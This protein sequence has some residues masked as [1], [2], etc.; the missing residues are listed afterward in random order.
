MLSIWNFAGEDTSPEAGKTRLTY[1]IKNA[2]HLYNMRYIEDLPYGEEPGHALTADEIAGVTFIVK[3]DIDWQS[4]QKG[5]Q[6]YDT[7]SAAGN[8]QLFSL[9]GKLLDETGKTIDSVTRLNCD[10]P[11]VSRI[12]ARDTLVGEKSVFG[13]TKEITGISVTEVSNALYGIY[14]SDDPGKRNAGELDTIRPSGLVNV[15]Y[16]TIKDLKL[17]RITVSGNQFVGSFCGINAGKTENLETMN[18]DGTSLIAGNQ[19]VGGIMGFQM[20]TTND[21][22]ISGLTNRARVEGVQ[23]VGGIVGM[24]RNDFRVFHASGSGLVWSELTELSEPAKSLFADPSGLTVK[25]SDCKNYGAVAGCYGTDLKEVY[26]PGASGTGVAG[27][28][29]E[30][31]YIGG[32]VSY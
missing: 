2:R 26:A 16:G 24:V 5:K 28:P 11:S 27:D 32:I 25:I 17:E 12:R 9:N 29:E 19:H 4:F 21:L 18:T 3:S 13:D 7:Y 1:S 30:S 6:L 31:R 14:N 23:A 8:I 22:V 15:N 20:P 10:F